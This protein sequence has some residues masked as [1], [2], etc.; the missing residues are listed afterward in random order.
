MEMLCPM[1]ETLQTPTKQD[2][3][4]TGP[5]LVLF[6]LVVLGVAL[7]VIYKLANWLPTTG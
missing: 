6:G 2:E 1:D 3:F 4:W 5:K 7:A